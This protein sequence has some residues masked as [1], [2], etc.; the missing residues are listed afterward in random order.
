MSEQ[1]VICVVEFYVTAFDRFVWDNPE[2]SVISDLFPGKS[3]AFGIV[4]GDIEPSLFNTKSAHGLSPTAFLQE[5][6]DSS[7]WSEG[8]LVGAGSRAN[9]TA[10]RDVTW[11]RIKASLSE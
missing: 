6:W 10:V 3:I 5:K 11:G 7:N 1:P 4:L 9:D 8:L 2:E